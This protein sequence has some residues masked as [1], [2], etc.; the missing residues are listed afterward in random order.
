MNW[1]MHFLI[2]AVIAAALLFLIGEHNIVSLVFIAAIG[3]FSALIPDLD[4]AYSKGRRLLDI[5]FILFAAL[6]AY[7]SECG[8]RICVP[9]FEMVIIFLILIGVYFVF[10]FLLG[11]KHRGITHTLAAA[12]VFAIIMAILVGLQFG[13]AALAGYLSHLI[14]DRKLKFL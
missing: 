12:I 14:A 8:V 9:T 2:G 11:Q 3:G 5:A 1:K 4:L 13:I 7:L 6:I 10:F